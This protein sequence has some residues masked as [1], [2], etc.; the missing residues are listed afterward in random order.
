MN[1]T[2]EDISFI[3]ADGKTKIRAFYWFKKD[4]VKIGIL[5]IVHG[6][7]E[8]MERYEDFINYMANNGFVV[9]MHDQL[10]HGS[11][12]LPENYGF[13]ADEN[14]SEYVLQDILTLNIKT[15]ET[16]K[17]LKIFMLGHSMGSFFARWFVER[18]PDYVDGAIFMGTSGPNPMATSGIVLINIIKAIRG[19]KYRS[20]LVNNLSVGGYTKLIENPQTPHDWISTKRETVEKYAADSRCTFIF[21]VSGYKDFITVMQHVNKEEWAKKINK[22]LPILMVSGAQDPVGDFGKGVTIVY[23]TL[24]EAGHENVAMK[25]YEGMRHEPLNEIE[26]E[27]VYNDIKDWLFNIADPYIAC[28]C[29]SRSIRRSKSCAHCSF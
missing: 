9:C 19:G 4:I 20:K 29:M 6:M 5:Q 2:K 10:G 27:Q 7:C 26:N 14:G 13:F 16:F 11:S 18:Y 8:H 28:T 24:K 15:K 25:L 12:S 21:T 1:I 17:K 23:N 3:S 22:E